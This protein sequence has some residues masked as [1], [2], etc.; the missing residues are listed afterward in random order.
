MTT[1]IGT[2]RLSPKRGEDRGSWGGSAAARVPAG[3]QAVENASAAL[4]AHDHVL[5]P[6]AEA[7][8]E[9]DRRL[10]GERHSRLPPRPGLPREERPLVDVEADP[11]THPVP[12]ACS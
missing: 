9:Q 6:N 10:V 11:V 4:G 2:K 8:V 12:E 7:P 3:L 5:D 1:R